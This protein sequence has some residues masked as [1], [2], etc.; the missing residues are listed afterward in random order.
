MLSQVT[1]L[2]SVEHLLFFFLTSSLFFPV[3]QDIGQYTFLTGLI[4]EIT[5]SQTSLD[6]KGP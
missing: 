5:G 3:K 4:I 1:R 6:W 2:G